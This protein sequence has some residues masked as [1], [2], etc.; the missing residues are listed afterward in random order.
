MNH[1]HGPDG[2]FVSSD[3]HGTYCIEEVEFLRSCAVSDA[4]IVRRM[5]TTAG[6]L[7]KA[8]R[9]AGRADLARPFESL[10]A[11]TRAVGRRCECGAP[12]ASLSGKRCV[13]CGHRARVAKVYGRAA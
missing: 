8:L 2:R 9:R 12:I 11:R 6:A 3:E 4:E 7:G 5:G 1:Q 10:Y 13:P